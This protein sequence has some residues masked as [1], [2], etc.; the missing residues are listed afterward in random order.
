MLG[1]DGGDPRWKLW[2]EGVRTW[3]PLLISVCAI[4]LTIFQ[5]TQGRKH[6]RLSVQPRIDFRLN[7]DE[8]GAVT[9]KMVNVGFGPAIVTEVTL[10]HGEADLGKVDLDA[11]RELDRRLGREGDDW[12]TGCFVMDGE[13]VLR[14]GDE[15]V[16]YASSPAP[17]LNTDEW[18]D[19]VIDY[20]KIQ[21]N[22]RYCSFYEDCW[23]ADP[24]AGRGDP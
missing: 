4:S 24:A 5:A 16:L 2:A 17:G 19:K 3:L 12:D 8:T 1:S 7:E 15:A 13:Y 21:L 20:A 6:T 11:C 14:A 10:G 9:I 22:A 18:R 23:W